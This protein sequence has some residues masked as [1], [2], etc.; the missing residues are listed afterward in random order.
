MIVSASRRTDLPAFYSAWFLNRLRE[1]YALVRHPRNPR[2]VRC[3]PLTPPEADYIVFWTRD[4]RPLLPG[5][6][7]LD[8]L[9]L[10]YS[11]LFTVTPYGPQ[12]EGNLPDPETRLEAF[13]AL[14]ERVG[15]LRVDWRYDPILFT[16]RIDAAFH[17]RSFARLAERLRGHTRRCIVSFL[18][19]YAKTRRNL[20][21]F[22]LREGTPEERLELLDSLA[23]QAERCGMRLQ[24]CAFSPAAGP[25]GAP[26]SIPPGEAARGEV[27][28]DAESRAPSPAPRA[29]PGACIDGRRISAFLG[30]PVGAGKDPGQRARCLCARSVDIGAYDTC[31]HGCLYCYA[32][33][34]RA[35][36]AAEHR[37]HDPSSPLLVG[38]L[39][40]GDRIAGPC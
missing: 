3:V 35:A 17:R 8:R 33:R 37:R 11:F 18:E 26:A 22:A 31:L 12:L 38:N 23:E 13:A 15:P 34:G 6:D 29:E 21:P 28:A 27:A 40:A 19:P 9:G 16:D 24:T 36:A 14:A 1:G 10:G 32:T 4:P 2:Q 30:R 5:L 7:E 25:A 20:A 39:Q